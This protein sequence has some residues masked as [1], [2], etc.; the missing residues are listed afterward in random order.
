M[1][2]AGPGMKVR[3][4]ADSTTPIWPPFTLKLRMICCLK[5]LV[6]LVRGQS[7]GLGQ[8]VGLG[9]CL[10][11]QSSGLGMC[12]LQ[13]SVGL[14]KNVGLGRCLLRQSM[15]SGM[16]LLWQSMGWCLQRQSVG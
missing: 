14:G 15:G 16:C 3:V 11:R 8:T 6:D 12:L 5:Y 13:Q 10:L 1:T 2:L 4:T 9:K 7:V